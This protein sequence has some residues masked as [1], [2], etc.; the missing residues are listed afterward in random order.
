MRLRDL[1][2]VALGLSFAACEGRTASQ[3]EIAVDGNGSTSP[4]AGSYTY[5]SGATVEVTA[6]P[7]VGAT[8]TGWSGAATGAANP[9]SVIVEGEQKLVAR[10]SGGTGGSGSSGGPRDA[11]SGASSSGSGDG[12][13]SGSSGGSSGA[14][15]SGS[16]GSSGGSSDAG[17]GGSSGGDAGEVEPLP[18]NTVR[19]PNGR[20]RVELSTTG[21]VLRYRITVDG[22]QVLAP[23]EIGIRSDGVEIGQ[24]ATLGSFTSKSVDEQYPF[25][26]AHAMAVNKA[27]EASVPATSGSESYTVDVHVA[28][29]GVG[30][31][32]RLAAKKGR[33]IEAER[34]AWRFDGNPTV[35]VA[36]Q[37]PGYEQHYR[38]KTLSTLGT[39]SY[40]MPL[41][42]KINNLYVS[43]TEAAVTDYGDMALKAGT[44]GVLQ[45]YLY[46]DQSGWTTDAAV[47][48]P[49]RVTILG[50]DLTALTNSTLVQSLSP[51][52]DP[53]LDGADWIKPGRSSWQWMAIGA[54]KFSDQQQW[55]DWT[56]QLGFEYYLIDDG[57]SAWSN[58]WQSLQSVVTYA[59]GKGVKIWLWVHSNEVMNASARQSYFKKASDMGIAG[60]KIDFPPAC[61]RSVATWYWDTARDGAKYKLL[62]D[63]HGAAKPSG[64]ERTWPNVLTRE[65]VRGHEYHMTRYNRVLEAAHDSILPFTRYLAG[66]GDYTPT[67]FAASELQGNTWAHEL[68][69]P[70]AFL[71]PFL[72]YGGHPR[73]YV[74]NAAADVL[75]AIPAVWDESTVLPGAEPGKVAAFA[76]RSG[77]NWFVGILNGADATTLNLPLSFLGSGTWQSIRLGDVAGKADAWDRQEGEVSASTTLQV[78]LS[79]RGGFVAW[80]KQ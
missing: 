20:V 53:S 69:Q 43:I 79:G 54:P 62:L 30:I 39:A 28:D 59:T 21:G 57:W 2:P 76:R 48:Q 37:D 35:W 15:S 75:K 71:S 65:G 44:G 8:F 55:V 5:V 49:W 9:V 34:S 10:F 3:L 42:A 77:K 14:G 63:F 6:I 73:D 11:G 67:V 23:S 58:A 7:A 27:N 13:S 61:S 66:V 70:I 50:D 4:P 74:A 36:Q 26:G 32:L 46:A 1:T 60:V 52:R 29:D 25:F 16:S 40:G 78:K 18:P 56:Q 22:K 17:S 33:K 64:M 47:V 80:F 24:N 19:S 41:T 68:A 51:P 72:C 45:G 12:G 38:S 31:R